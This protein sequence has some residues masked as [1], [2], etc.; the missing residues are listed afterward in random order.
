MF[1]T[2]SQ[3][4]S[5]VS[6]TPRRFPKDPRVVEEDIQLPVFLRRRDHPFDVPRLDTSA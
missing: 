2:R 4:F 1:I 3:V 6:R 5:S